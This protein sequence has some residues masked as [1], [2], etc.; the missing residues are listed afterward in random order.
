M[1]R[2]ICSWGKCLGSTCPRLL[3][4]VVIKRHPGSLYGVVRCQNASGCNCEISQPF[5]KGGNIIH[6]NHLD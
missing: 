5:E 4:Y 1:S 3:G 2:G 6:S